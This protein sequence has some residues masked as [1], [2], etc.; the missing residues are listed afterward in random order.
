MPRD[1]RDIATF[2]SYGAASNKTHQMAVSFVL[3]STPN[4]QEREMSRH[5]RGLVDTCFEEGQYESGISVLEQ[6]RSSH[7]KPSALVS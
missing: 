6:L 4:D 3:P 2:N 5:Q 1:W 7:V